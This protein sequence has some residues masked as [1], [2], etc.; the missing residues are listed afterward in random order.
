MVGLSFLLLPEELT[1]QKMVQL[2]S[3]RL[4]EEFKKSSPT[5][6]EK[7]LQAYAFAGQRGWFYDEYGANLENMVKS[8]GPYGEFHGLLRKLNNTEEPYTKATLVRGIEEIPKP[9]LSLL[10]SLTPSDI[11]NIAVRNSKFWGDGYL[12]RMVLASPPAGLV[13]GGRFPEGMMEIDESLLQPIRDWHSRLG[14]PK[15]SEVDGRAVQDTSKSVSMIGFSAESWEAYY[16]YGDALKEIMQDINIA[17]LDGSYTRFPEKALRI[18][19]LFASFGGFTV[20]NLNHWAKA[21]AITE[22]W[23]VDLHS[24]YKQVNSA[25]TV[26][27]KWTNS[28]RVLNVIQSR[29]YPTSRE[30][31]Q[32]AGLSSQVVA[33]VLDMLTHTGKVISEKEGKTIR[34]RSNTPQPTEIQQTSSDEQSPASNDFGRLE[35]DMSPLLEDASSCNEPPPECCYTCGRSKFWQRPDGCWVCG[36]CHPNPADN[37][38]DLGK[39]DVPAESPS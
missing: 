5:Q 35:A 13:K 30:I 10:G 7:I 2:M 8:S 19:A 20:I 12:A 27:P 9:Y 29:I 18:A 1:P 33:E 34:Y 28:Q 3:D 24:L 23:R 4:P 37:A 14:I 26:S 6:K 25:K 16:R 22:R 21:Q 11:A 38:S 31:Q 39:A 15:M 17:D 32:S 36:I